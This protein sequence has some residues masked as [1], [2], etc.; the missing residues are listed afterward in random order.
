MGCDQCN[1][2]NPRNPECGCWSCC[3]N[4]YVR[5]GKSCQ[6]VCDQ[7]QRRYK[8][9]RYIINEQLQNSVMPG[10][11]YVFI[12][13]YKKCTPDNYFGPC[14]YKANLQIVNM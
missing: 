13:D 5:L 3:G 7:A 14:C 8:A 6:G 2:N 1:Q 10:I 4:W 11:V 12:M 9:S